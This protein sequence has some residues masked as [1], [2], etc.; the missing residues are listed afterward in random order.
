MKHAKWGEIKMLG[1]EARGAAAVVRQDNIDN[2]VIVGGGPTGLFLAIKLKQAGLNVSIVEP[3]TDYVRSGDYRPEVFKE[4]SALLGIPITPSSSFHI[5]DIERQLLEIA[6]KLEIPII[7]KRFVGF[8][9]AGIQVSNAR[10][11]TND[12]APASAAAP[13]SASAAPPASASAANND[14]DAKR[15]YEAKDQD[16]LP[17]QLAIDCTGTNRVLIKELNRA[18]PREQKFVV[19]PT[20]NNPHKHYLLARVELNSEQAWDLGENDILDPENPRYLPAMR[21]FR[22][23][24]WTAAAPPFSYN[25]IFQKNKCHIYVQAP[26]ELKNTAQQQ[27]W[28]ETLYALRI[29]SNVPEF[30]LVHSSRKTPHKQRMAHFAIDPHQ[31]TPAY[32][33]GSSNEP[34]IVHAGDASADMPFRLGKGLIMGLRRA[35]A[36]VNSLT[37]LGGKIIYIDFNQ[38]DRLLLDL[39]RERIEEVKEHFEEVRQRFE[40][41][42]TD[43]NRYAIRLLE[44][45]RDYLGQHADEKNGF[46]P[47]QKSIDT[48]LKGLQILCNA[49]ELLAPQTREHAAA[50]EM[51]LEYANR[52]K[53]F[54]TVM[55][56]NRNLKL[57]E[58]Y[59]YLSLAILD[60][61]F[62]NQHANEKIALYSNLIIVA[63][64]TQD[65]NK[66]IMLAEKALTEIIPHVTKDREKFMAKVTFHLHY[67]RLEK[68]KRAPQNIDLRIV[69]DVVAEAQTAIR[70]LRANNYANGAGTQ[71]LTQ[72]MNAVLEKYQPR[73]NPVNRLLR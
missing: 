26:A 57:A 30:K 22:A 9:A 19:T 4:I 15:S 62:P 45:S 3:R 35:N 36:F 37:V 46:K 59:Y 44:T 27:R 52:F 67:A 21:D 5:K 58:K 8:T 60:Q 51:L 43:V 65:H 29:D 61:H 48:A 31:V 50:K 55:N 41:C 34:M 33:L 2:I 1:A 72:Q 49:T 20:G 17:C 39:N 70:F 47:D 6:R 16:I 66:A 68:L 23:L 24:G 53:L 73:M 32:Y 11:A 40:D 10:L 13:A 63:H 69:G 18:Y 28:I 71:T 12:S 25:N 56:R 14:G 7:H 64:K 42:E 38:Y 54:A